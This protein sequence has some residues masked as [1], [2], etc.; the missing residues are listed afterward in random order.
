MQIL[1]GLLVVGIVIGASTAGFFLTD[2]H[3]LELQRQLT[4]MFQDLSGP[5]PEVLFL[6]QPIDIISQTTTTREAATESCQ[7]ER[8]KVDSALY[9]VCVDTCRF[10]STGS[11]QSYCWGLRETTH[12]SCDNYE[13]DTQ[14]IDNEGTIEV[15]VTGYRAKDT[16]EVS[17]ACVNRFR[18]TEDERKRIADL[19]EDLEGDL[20]EGGELV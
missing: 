8:T 19:E 2:F 14:F 11:S 12:A 16:V 7:R 4:P 3:S 18:V 13:Y 17:C 20:A 10:R 15:T 5:C 9:D 6:D 1:V